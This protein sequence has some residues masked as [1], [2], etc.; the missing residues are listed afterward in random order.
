M[1]RKN[2]FI[3]TTGRLTK[4]MF[5][6]ENSVD[7]QNATTENATAIDTLSLPVNPKPDSLTN[8]I[9]L[10]SD[11]FEQ[12]WKYIDS[13]PIYSLTI[14]PK[15]NVASKAQLSYNKNGTDYTHPALFIPLKDKPLYA[16][17]WDNTANSNYNFKLR[18][19]NRGF[20]G[21]LDA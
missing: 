5:L 8:K 18:L 11:Y 6:N 12:Y 9:T 20:D 16:P 21:E 7:S 3:E 13:K 4:E 2:K 14:S 10:G 17:L 15:Y 1:F 19:F